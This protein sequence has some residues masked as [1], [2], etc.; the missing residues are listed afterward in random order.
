MQFNDDHSGVPTFMIGMII[1]VMAGVGLSIIVD[2]RFKFSS[3]F[4]DLQEEIRVNG[5]LVDELKATHKERTALL[6]NSGDKRRRQASEL[7]KLSGDLKSQKQKITT[8]LAAKRELG[9]SITQLEDD[10]LRYR[11]GYRQKAWAEAVGENL[12]NLKLRGGREYQNVS[13]TRVTEA[14]LEVS[15]ENGFARIPAVD[16]EPKLRDR[17]QIGVQE[18]SKPSQK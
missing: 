6:E 13:I 7:V 5:D 8:L 9:L 14:G 2:K 3:D 1:L 11:T 16:L 15:H 4:S 18:P 17:F 10:K 12:G